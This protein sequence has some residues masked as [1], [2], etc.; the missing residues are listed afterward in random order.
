MASTATN[1][2]TDITKISKVASGSYRCE[3]DFSQL[4]KINI[5]EYIT[6]PSFLAGGHEWSI[7]C[8]PLGNKERTNDAYLSLFLDLRTDSKD[9][10]AIFD[11]NLLDKNGR[12]SATQSNRTCHVFEKSGYGWGWPKFVR[13]E[14]LKG[15]YVI[16]NHFVIV[17]TI[18]VL[19]ASA[20]PVVV[21]SSD[22]H[23]HFGKLLEDKETADVTFDV[24]GELFHVHRLVLAT[25]SPVF[26]AELYGTMHEHNSTE[27][28]IY[29]M[30]PLVFRS[31]LHFIYTDSLPD[32]NNGDDDD[33]SSLIMDDIMMTQHLLVAA[34]RYALDRLKSMCEA[35]LY[36]TVTVD[37][38]ATTL[39]IAEQHNCHQLKEVCIDFTAVP[40]NYTK[41]ASTDGYDHLKLCCPLI[42]EDIQHKL[43]ETSIDE[44]RCEESGTE[45]PCQSVKPI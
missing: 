20:C 22:L 32:D 45:S 10:S 14:D 19:S 41:I 2:N 31:L 5:G 15:S 21:P 36:K 40:G 39:A 25:R 38:V 33:D 8:Y 3:I 9:V 16:D 30:E 6:S 11:F 27:I 4:E 1:N 12:P 35:K 43:N 44:L 37:T 13:V 29:D 23:L 34:D 7:T 26:K 24:N 17:C 28:K 42:I 18:T